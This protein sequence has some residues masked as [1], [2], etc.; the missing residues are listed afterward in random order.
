M[1][2]HGKVAALHIGAHKTGTTVLQKYLAEHE[3]ELR[4][5]GVYYLRRSELARYAGWGERLAE[6]P[7]PLRARLR[8]FRLDPRFRVLI[9]SN[10]NLM[11]R[12]FP[13]GGDGRLYPQVSR[14]AAALGAALRGSG[15]K[16][17]LTV[18]PQPD[19]LESYYLQTVHQG[20]DE[21]FED[22]LARVDLTALSWRPIVSALQ[23]TFG[24]DR[25]EVVDFRLIKQGQEAYLRHLLR[26][27]DPEWD[28]EIDYTE[29]R[30]RSISERGLQMALAANRHLANGAQRRALREFLQTHFSNV[31]FPR[32]V[33]LGEARR[34]ALWEHYREDYEQV[35]GSG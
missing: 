31:D 30:N 29:P 1:H 33:L 9:G 28:V 3:P 15:C 26:R 16:I 20:R 17:V 21:P 25:V 10:E 5:R 22:W 35:V 14:N 8:K 23:R 18:R 24:L 7:A 11:G 6:D 34:A 2:V 12:P 4:R 19:F 32:P 13:R 27:I